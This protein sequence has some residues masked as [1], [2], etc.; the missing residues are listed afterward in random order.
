MWDCEKYKRNRTDKCNY[1]TFFWGVPA[2]GY[3]AM[4]NDIRGLESI[5]HKFLED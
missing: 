2:N 5:P 1:S 4:L 3:P